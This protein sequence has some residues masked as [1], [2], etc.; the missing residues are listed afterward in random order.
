M[1]V[2][3]VRHAFH[4]FAC[5]RQSAFSQQE[6]R[7]SVV[8]PFGTGVELDEVVSPVKLSQFH[9]GP[10]AGAEL[11]IPRRQGERSVALPRRLFE[12]AGV[13]LNISQSEMR[14]RVFRTAFDQTPA[15]DS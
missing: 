7:S 4:R 10:G 2:G 3:S 5:F 13:A 8:G 14:L 6:G 1:V 12:H 15:A 9:K 11:I